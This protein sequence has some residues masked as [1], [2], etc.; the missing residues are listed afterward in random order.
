M[1]VRKILIVS[2]YYLPE[3]NPRVFRWSS[4]VSEWL[5]LGYEISLIT[6]SQDKSGSR[7]QD[8]LNI[9]RLPENLIGKIRNK[10]SRTN[11]EHIEKSDNELS[12]SGNS[13]IITKW[14]KILYYFVIKRLQW[15]DFAWTWILNARKAA[16]LHLENNSDI[17]VVISVSHPFS[18]HVVGYF[19]K[20]KYPD[21]RWIIDIG[22]PFSFLVE[23]PP[24]NFLIYNR[25]NKFIER[26]FFSLSD[27][28]S[29]TTSETKNE[30]LKL[31]PENKEKIKIIPPVLSTEATNMFRARAKKR[32]SNPKI[33][34]LVYV[35][36]L[37]SGIRNPQKLLNILEAVRTS[38]NR[39]FELHFIGPVNDINILKLANS[40]TYFHGAV[41]H[42]AA[43]K[44]MLD[45][46]ILI[47]IGNSTRFQLPSKLV[48][49]VC[50]GN[51]VLNVTSTHDDSSQVF[52]S[53]YQMSKTVC[54]SGDITND[55]V[56]EVS[57]YIESVST[58][59]LIPN[60]AYLSK[61]S[62]QNISKQYELL[63]F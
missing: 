43:L 56:R 36:T 24:N 34:K 7:P 50:T 33:L 3:E 42:N 12:I 57:D 9:I 54:L 45:A 21:I 37:Y 11:T 39:D 14:I 29:V 17:D 4:I 52:L 27:M 51:P 46:D 38:L 62:V 19:V 47:N 30:Y 35:G 15:P 31:F 53:R 16:I 63:L 44:F 55:I 20:R 5:S 61:Y 2:Y 23:A 1:K 49:Y 28:I 48:E 40:Y 8:D 41:S 22:D 18:S 32:Q 25:L 26:T 59:S 6:A 58:H 10:I 13:V 60:D